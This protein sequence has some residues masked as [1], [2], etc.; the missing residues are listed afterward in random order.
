MWSL[1]DGSEINRFTW[2]DDIL[3][4]A[5]SRDGRLLAISDLSA[6]LTLVDAMD[7]YRTLAQTAVSEV[8]GMIKFSPDCRCLYALF[9]DGVA[10][11]HF[12]PLDINVEND[13][14]FTLDV[15][16]D[17][18]YYHPWEFELCSETG[19]LLG[20][21]FWFPSEGDSILSRRPGL[22]CVLNEKSVLTV[23]YVASTIE[24]LQLD[25]L[26][27]ESARVSITTAWEV[28]LTL[29]GD[30][31]YA[32]TTTD[33]SP[34]TLVG[35]D[36]S[37][38]MFKPGKRVFEET[39]GNLVAVREGVLLQ[40]SCDTFELWNFELSEC[41]RSWTDLGAISKVIP[42]SKERVA[43]EVKSASQ[44][45]S[46]VIIVDTTREGIASTITID[47]NFIGCNSECHV[48]SAAHGNLQMQCGDKVLW[49]ISEPSKNSGRHR[50]TTFSP[51]EQYC[52][53]AVQEVFFGTLSMY[54]LDVISGKTL[55]TLQPRSSDF[56]DFST[57]VD[58]DCKF[59]ADEEYITCFSG[60]SRSHFLQLC[61]VK[62]GDLLCEIAVESHVYSLAACPRER[63]IAIGFDDS[64]MNFKVLRVKLPGDKHRRKRAKGQVSLIRNK[65]TMQ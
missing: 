38:G 10:R 1:T 8:C 35:W 43:F 37:S 21:P 12:F 30:T 11:C 52:V 53:F 4:F 20:D 14:D 63:L 9:F 25:E 15:L 39:G 45:E 48:I 46:K 51:T 23:A 64:K 57:V 49:K 61:N 42:I 34:A 29:N 5:W 62:S 65:V 58:F 40:T 33:G 2:S 60:L 41:I 55:R 16:P 54:V 19:F 27:K 26:T 3:S 13:S 31:L 6:S 28:A 47:G 7:D 36:I 18:A 56:P 24:M 59:V 22:A 17:Q 50:C 44:E 32:I